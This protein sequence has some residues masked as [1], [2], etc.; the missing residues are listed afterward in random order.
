MGGYGGMGGGYGMGTY[1]GM[2]GGYGM[3]R[4]G[5]GGGYGMNN[6]ANINNNNNVQGAGGANQQG[7]GQG[8]QLTRAQI[9]LSGAQEITQAFVSLVEVSIQFAILAVSA[10]C[11]YSQ[12]QQVNQVPGAANPFGDALAPAISRTVASSPTTA[13][14]AKKSAS[15]LSK[16]TRR[17]L[18]TVTISVSLYFAVTKLLGKLNKAL[19]PDDRSDA[20]VSHAAAQHATNYI[21]DRSVESQ[22]REDTQDIDELADTTLQT[23]VGEP[24]DSLYT[25]LYAYEGKKSDELSFAQNDHLLIHEQSGDWWLASHVGKPEQQGLVPSNY[26][27]SLNKSK[28][29]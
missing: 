27:Q 11:T 2:G 15:W 7:Q 21:A 4:F 12:V 10:W 6:S 26:L 1:G 25:T 16:A 3:N 20:M 13:H 9:V 18:L 17:Q 22:P 14:T 8:Q 24:G 28:L 29:G 23:V 19:T 5:M